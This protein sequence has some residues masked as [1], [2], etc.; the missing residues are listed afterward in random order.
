[1]GAGARARGGGCAREE[2][3]ASAAAR[4][5]RASAM[6]GPRRRPVTAPARRARRA[7][8]VRCLVNI[9]PTRETPVISVTWRLLRLRRLRLRPIGV[10]NP[11]ISLILGLEGAHDLGIVQPGRQ[12]RL[13][14]L[15]GAAHDE[16]E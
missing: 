14:E 8:R 11:L 4:H 5:K 6:A 15:L 12:A 3:D 1:M 7:P 2:A 16:L 9:E 10:A 13:V